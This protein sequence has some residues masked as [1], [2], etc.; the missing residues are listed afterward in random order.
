MHKFS[1]STQFENAK[2][3]LL[4]IAVT[5]IEPLGSLYEP[6]SQPM[7]QIQ[8]NESLMKFGGQKGIDNFKMR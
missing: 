4:W 7:L 8:W 1:F 3:F 2:C 5:I 6:L